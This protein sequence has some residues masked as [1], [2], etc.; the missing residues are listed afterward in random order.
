[1]AKLNKE[2]LKVKVK[3]VTNKVKEF[4]DDNKFYICWYGVGFGMIVGGIVLERRNYNKKFEEAWRAA[5]QA[6]DNGNLDYDFGPYKVM[7]FF[8]PKTGEFIGET[9]CHGETVNAF[10]NLK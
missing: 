6:Y 2:N 8:E 1:M 4:V 5:K 7:K 9:I 10:I 3:N